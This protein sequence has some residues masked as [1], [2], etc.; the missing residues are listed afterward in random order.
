MCWQNGFTYLGHN[1]LINDYNGTPTTFD[2]IVYGIIKGGVKGIDPR[3]DGD[4]IIVNG[5]ISTTVENV[6]GTLSEIFDGGLADA[7]DGAADALNDDYAIITLD[8]DSLNFYIFDKLA[9]GI[10]C[11]LTIP[12]NKVAQFKKSKI[13]LWY[14]LRLLFN[15]GNELKISITS[16]MGGVKKQ[17]ENTTKLF[18]MLGL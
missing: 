10:C 15:Q 18:E 16:K 13:L 8:K 3:L 5:G 14:T 1:P 9:S 17:S 6:V 2:S 11:K 12:R 7:L 4:T